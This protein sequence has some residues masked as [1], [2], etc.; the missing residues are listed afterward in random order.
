MKNKTIHILGGGTFSHVRSHL[1]FG[2]TALKLHELCDQRFETM[3][4]STWLTAMAESPFCFTKRIR[5]WKS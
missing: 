4:I 5:M 3:D 2:T 1:A